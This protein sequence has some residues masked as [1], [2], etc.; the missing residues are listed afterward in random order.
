[1]YRKGSRRLICEM[2]AGVDETVFRLDE[3]I[4]ERN[5]FQITLQTGWSLKKR[6]N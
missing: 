3:I 5:D 1:M 4:W 2:A 6:W